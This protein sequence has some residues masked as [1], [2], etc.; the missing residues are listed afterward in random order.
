VDL[1][2]EDF[3][4]QEKDLIAVR[5]NDNMVK[6]ESASSGRKEGEKFPP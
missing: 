5:K 3:F 2:G 4:R 1:G 6:G